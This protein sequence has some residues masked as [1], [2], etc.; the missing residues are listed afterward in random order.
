M[1]ADSLIAESLCTG[2]TARAPFDP[3]LCWPLYEASRDCSD[4]GGWIEYV[5][6]GWAVRLEGAG[7]RGE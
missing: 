3:A 7:D 2:D 4:M 1:D 5:G 6:D